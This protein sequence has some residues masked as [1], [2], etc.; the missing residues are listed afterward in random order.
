MIARLAAA[1]FSILAATS[2]ALADDASGCA[3][4]K[5]SVAREQGWFATSL[6]PVASGASV[7]LAPESYQLALA[8]DAAKGFPVAPERAPKPG[9]YAG[10]INLASLSA[11]VYQ[12][13][14]SDEAWID[15]AQN[16][17][18]VKSKDFSGQ[19]EC[20]GVRKSVRFDLKAAPA[21]VEISNASGAEIRLGHRARAIAPFR[22]SKPRR[23]RE[24]PAPAHRVPRCR[25]GS[26]SA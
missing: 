1:A 26:P 3:K 25:R 18:L 7:T 6:K 21:I 19:K 24:S 5:W 13:T 9:A 20:P 12:I 23:D 15:V 10:L 22:N 17:A 11:G 4:F 14:L 2:C 8:V 16:G